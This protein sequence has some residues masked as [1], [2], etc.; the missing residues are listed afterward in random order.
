MLCYLR[1]PGRPLRV[2]EPPAALISFIAEQ[3]D[4]PP[5]AIDGSE[6]NRWRHAAELQERLGLRPFGTR[7]ADYV[8]ATAEQA[9]GN[10][11]GFRPLRAMPEAD[12][13]AA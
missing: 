3:I 11:D 12:L 4:V 13:L 5:E 2:N 6:Q 9:T 7:P 10:P 1:H 8:W